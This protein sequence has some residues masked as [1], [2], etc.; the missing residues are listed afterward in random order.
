MRVEELLPV[1]RQRLITVQVDALL[2]DAAKLLTDTHR[3][4]L[5]VCDQNGAMVGAITKTDVVRRIARSPTNLNTITA[6]AVM[7][8]DVTFC[9]PNDSVHDVL[10][11]MKERGFVHI[12]VID[13]HGQPCGVVNARDALQ[14]LLKEVKDEELVLRAYVMGVGYK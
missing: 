14:A 9:Q 6:E 12:P 13:R 8:R 3:A 4:L 7:T 5:V 2:T 11:I 10:T 1:A